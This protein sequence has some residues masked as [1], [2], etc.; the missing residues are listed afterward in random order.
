MLE[1]HKHKQPALIDLV[2]CW[3]LFLKHQL[4]QHRVH[5]NAGLIGVILCLQGIFS[6]SE[7]EREIGPGDQWFFTGDIQALRMSDAL[8]LHAGRSSPFI[9]SEP[10]KLWELF[11]SYELFW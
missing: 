3:L 9:H 6:T 10:I 2:S 11:Y 4:K 8:T 7:E 1:A 5:W